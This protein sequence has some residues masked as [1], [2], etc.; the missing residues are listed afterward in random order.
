MCD[1]CRRSQDRNILDTEIIADGSVL[2]AVP[3]RV[4]P[5]RSAYPEDYVPRGTAGHVPEDEEP[6]V[7][8]NV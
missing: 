2:M 6:E 4:L 7:D 5:D 3:A 1:K 8:G